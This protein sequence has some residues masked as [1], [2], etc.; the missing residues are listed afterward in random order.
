MLIFIP[1]LL[2]ACDEE[3]SLNSSETENIISINAESSADF[4]SDSSV[5][6]AVYPENVVN[7]TVSVEMY[8]ESMRY[9]NGITDRFNTLLAYQKRLNADG[10]LQLDEEFKK[11]FIA[12]IEDYE[13]FVKGFY[14]SPSTDADF[15]IFNNFSDTLYYDEL[16]SNNYRAYVN[17]YEN[18]YLDSA[19]SYN[20]SIK[21]SYIA[22]INVLDKYKLF[23]DSK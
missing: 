7:G 9:I 2:M 17:K 15:E 11:E 21:T 4:E 10:K 18:F 8:E 12:A 6:L 22:F 13:V 1:F 23:T 3:I 14:L 20:Q 16:F 5:N 19:A